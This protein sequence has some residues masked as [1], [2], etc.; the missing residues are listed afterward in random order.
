MA[1][2]TELAD[3]YTKLRLAHEQAKAEVSLAFV[4]MKSA[5]KALADK[6]IETPDQAKLQLER[7]G[8]KFRVRNSADCS[9]TVGNQD[10]ILEWLKGEVGDTKDFRK[11]VVVKKNVLDYVKERMAKGVPEEEFPKALKV[12]QW[13]ALAVE[14]WKDFA[15]QQH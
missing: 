4:K 1:D 12:K 8:M 11:E 9:I 6:M 5:E 10:E 7:H 15:S 13:P 3:R 2:A 14:G